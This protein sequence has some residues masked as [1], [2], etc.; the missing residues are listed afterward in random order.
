[1]LGTVLAANPGCRT[2]APRILTPISWTVL[3]YNIHHGEGLDG[4][5]DLARIAEV[6]QRSGADLVAL[7]EVDRRAQRTGGVDQAAELGRLT[8]LHV[9]FGA[10]MPF[11]GGEYGQAILSRLPLSQPAI[12]QLPQRAGREPRIALAVQVGEKPGIW[13]VSTH[14][15]HQLEDVRVEQ[16]RNLDE[17]FGNRPE[18]VLLAGDF[19]ARPNSPPMQILKGW[20]NTAGDDPQPTIPAGRPRSRID[21]IGG[22]WRT[23]RTEVLEEP[24]ASDHRP[25]RA[26]IE[27]RPE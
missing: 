12:H 8:G 19:N 24:L 26:V 23:L 2:A 25:V 16:A 22:H 21:Y 9:V 13:F 5:V 3:S 14:L 15:D 17:L 18:P 6:I 1:M 7:Q 20:L 27:L 11:Q 10:A 4:K